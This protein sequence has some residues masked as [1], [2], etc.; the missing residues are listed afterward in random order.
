MLYPSHTEG[1]GRRPPTRCSRIGTGSVTGLDPRRAGHNAQARAKVG[2][3]D[4]TRIRIEV[5]VIIE[6][7]VAVMVTVMVRFRGSS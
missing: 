2:F 6:V 7:A 1:G 3:S 5:A 4:R